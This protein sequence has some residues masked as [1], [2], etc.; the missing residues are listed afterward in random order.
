MFEKN[1]IDPEEQEEI[2]KVNAEVKKLDPGKK[3]S[4]YWLTL[5][6]YIRDNDTWHFAKSYAL[7]IIKNWR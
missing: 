6:Y 2:D 3:R 7:A 4:L 1:I 5:K